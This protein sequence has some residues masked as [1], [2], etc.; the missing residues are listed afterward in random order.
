MLVNIEQSD[1]TDLGH[2]LIH[3]AHNLTDL[4]HVLIHMAHNL[5]DLAHVNKYMPKVNEVGLISG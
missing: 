1:L 2:V 4:S 3:M 5:A